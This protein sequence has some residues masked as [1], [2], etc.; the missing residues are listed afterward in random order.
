VYVKLAL[1]TWYEPFTWLAFVAIVVPSLVV[2]LW[3]VW[4]P[5]DACAGW[6]FRRVP[7]VV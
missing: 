4:Q 3:H 1:L 7:D 6:L 2:W 5:N